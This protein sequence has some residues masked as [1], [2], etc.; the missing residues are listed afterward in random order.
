MAKKH[1]P[2]RRSSPAIILYKG[3]A[4]EIELDPSLRYRSYGQRAV[5]ELLV[6]LTC[7]RVVSS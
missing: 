5:G 1:K 6:Q 7:K 2:P 4:G 3:A